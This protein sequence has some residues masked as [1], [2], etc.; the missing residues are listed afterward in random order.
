MT[1]SFQKVYVYGR[2]RGVTTRRIRELAAAKRLKLTRR[3]SSADAI[4]LA[5][6]TAGFAVSDGGELC[7]RFQRKA[8]ARLVSERYFRSQL[9]ILAVPGA[10]E[11]QYSEDQIAR[12]AG[13]NSAQLRD[14]FVL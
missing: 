4:V 7:L 3:P 6:S 5:H 13:L 11:L 8:D 2:L 9:G 1:I 10:S 14:P 12:H